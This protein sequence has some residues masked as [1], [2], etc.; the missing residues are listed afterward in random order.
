MINSSIWATAVA[1][2]V[3]ILLLR[4][5]APALPM[6]TVYCAFDVLRHAILFSQSANPDQYFYAFWTAK[7]VEHLLK[8]ALAVQLS[9]I[10]LG[11]NRRAMMILA[12]AGTALLLLAIIHAGPPESLQQMSVLA[13]QASF[14]SGMILFI[15][16]LASSFFAIRYCMI[17]AG[18]GFNLA[19]QLIF[20]PAY[21]RLLPL[22][23]IVTLTIWLVAL[24][25]PAV[26]SKDVARHGKQN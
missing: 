21:P 9:K 7:I 23:G 5:R 22:S 17:A 4:K 19:A 8:L 16:W 1:L 10:A 24:L 13:Q 18:L 11:K 20:S 15:A 2:S 6:L 14:V 26:P 12:P 3:L 25:L